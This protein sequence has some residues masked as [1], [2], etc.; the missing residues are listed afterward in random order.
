MDPQTFPAAATEYRLSRHSLEVGVACALLF[1]LAGALSV[2]VALSNLDGS[3]RHPIAAA[4]IF[5]VLWLCPTALGGWL[6]AAY[7]RYRLSV[8]ADT[9]RVTGCFQT[10]QVRLAVVTRAVWKSLIR[11][12]SL[13]LYE[14]DSRVT[15]RFDNHRFQ[16]RAE[17]I[18][19]LRTALAEETQEGWERFQARC[20]PPQVDYQVLQTEIHRLLRF[21]L[22]AW[23][24]ALPIMYAILIWTKLAGEVERLHWVAVALFP[25]ATAGL[26][27][28]GMWLAAR[29]DLDRARDRTDTR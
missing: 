1:G 25:L 11:G 19:L 29:G 8:S 28:A 2:A 3:F 4:A 17:L 12:G 24:T 6:I 27:M 18:R 9:I 20:T 7:F 13:V 5:G 10:R 14:R 22:I 23:A 16:E 15:I 21:A 26:I